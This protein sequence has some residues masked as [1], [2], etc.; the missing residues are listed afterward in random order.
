MCLG[1]CLGRW[2][3]FNGFERLIFEV[4]KVFGLFFVGITGVWV[5]V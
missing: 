3:G 2:D 4:L 1:G 5:G